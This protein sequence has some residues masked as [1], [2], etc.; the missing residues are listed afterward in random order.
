MP[1]FLRWGL[2]GAS[3]VFLVIQLVPYGRD[4]ANPP[5]RREPLWDSPRTR[6]L[7]VR[8]CF[9]CHSNETAWPWYSSVAPVSWLVHR[10]VVEGRR[11]L[12]Y[13]EW[14]RPQEEA[15][16]AAAAVRKGAMPPWNY[17]WARL[18]GPE[19]EELIHGLAVTLG[20][21]GKRTERE[22]DDD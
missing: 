6:A 22:K 21:K 2:I 20:E 14:D 11:D 3:M 8:S 16:G 9:D 5:L 19:R 12:N 13:S 18:S 7:A 1:R 4:H 15:P 10:D 17:P